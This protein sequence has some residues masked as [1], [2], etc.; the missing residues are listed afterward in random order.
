VKIFCFIVILVLANAGVLSAQTNA[1]VKVSVTTTNKPA[2]APAAPHLTRIDSDSV[3]FDMST[4]ARTATYRG[5]VRVD[6]PQMKLT[7]ARLVADLPQDGGHI[8][9]IVAETNVVIDFTDDKGQTNH[10][11]SDKAVYNF[12]VQG[13]VTNETVTLTGHAQVENAQGTLTGEPIVWN[14]ANDSLTAMNEAMTFR[15][16]LGDAMTKTNSSSANTNKLSA[17]K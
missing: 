14:R 8:N 12:N 11:T 15:Q 1:N 10:A 3:V 5:H 4:N 13:A 16:N 6:D 2:A 9:H 17:P 7:C